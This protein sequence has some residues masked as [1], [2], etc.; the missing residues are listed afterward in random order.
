[1][2]VKNR[3]RVDEVLYLCE[4]TEHNVVESGDLLRKEQVETAPEPHYSLSVKIRHVPHKFHGCFCWTRKEIIQF[5]RQ[6]KRA[7]EGN[8]FSSCCV[9][10]SCLNIPFPPGRQTMLW[11]RSM[12]WWSNSHRTRSEHKG[13]WLNAAQN[14]LSFIFEMWERFKRKKDGYHVKWVENK[15]RFRE[16]ILFDGSLLPFKFAD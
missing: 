13:S 4:G 11:K 7:R 15:Q 2:N 14:L 6:L 12:I 10:M 9:T 16:P 1:M 8:W 3:P 5:F